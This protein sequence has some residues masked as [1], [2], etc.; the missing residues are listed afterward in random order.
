[1]DAD[2]TL[3]E[4]QEYVCH[5]EQRMAMELQNIVADFEK[6]TGLTMT[7]VSVEFTDVTTIGQIPQFVITG[8][9]ISRNRF[10]RF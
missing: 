5:A 7:G 10:P 3:R 8:V 9:E 1:M 4:L 2:I 6:Q